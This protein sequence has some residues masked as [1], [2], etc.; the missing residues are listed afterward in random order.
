[1]QVTT[2]TVSMI[3]SD[4]VCVGRPSVESVDGNSV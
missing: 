3:V 1:M 4:Y 2:L